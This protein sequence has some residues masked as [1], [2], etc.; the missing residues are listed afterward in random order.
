MKRIIR[1]EK[2]PGIR[3]AGSKQ[4]PGIKL[5]HVSTGLADRL[6]PGDR[7]LAVDG[8]PIEDVL[9]FHYYSVFGMEPELDLLGADGTRRLQ[10]IR[11]EEL[12]GDSLEFE[13]LQFKTCGNDCVFCFIHQMPEGLREDLYLMD[14]DYRLGFL[15][16]NYVTLALAREH[17]LDRIIRQHLS[18][19]YLSVHATE[20]DLRNR[21]L[22]LKRSRDVHATIRRLLDGG[23][24]IHTQIVLLPG[25]NDGDVLE[26]TLT[27]LV[28]YQPGIL[29]LGIVPVGL[30]RHRERLDTL[31]GFDAAGCARLIDQIRPWQERSLAEFGS[32][33]VHLGDEFYLQAGRP[34]PP[35]DAYE[36]FFLIDNGIG[37]A[38]DF[39]DVV[40]AEA[41][42]WTEPE[43]LCR[44][45]ILTGGLG[46][47]LFRE[48]L[49]PELTSLPG[50]ELHVAGIDN[51]LFGDKI[52]VSGLLPGRELLA[53]RKRLPAE[54]DLL[55]L[56]PNT[57]NADELFLDDMS[58]GEFRAACDLPVLAPESGLLGAV[59]EFAR[60]TS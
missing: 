52:T 40:R 3:F 59:G 50:L 56:P 55:L 15:Y 6:A 4:Q 30:T 32:R 35:T 19:V 54:L 43:R 28:A 45:G 27:D 7:I 2:H 51:A 42:V 13:P 58:F 37:M 46:E 38:R 36:D 53:G 1:S 5:I 39:L 24:D 48:Q 20:M 57:L 49:L 16:G 9:D 21:L 33:F 26:R 47:K 17:E 14:E 18:P 60:R 34:L 10:K 12:E 23:I 44:V 41:R 8:E 31:D 11:S 25:W 22:G 29:S